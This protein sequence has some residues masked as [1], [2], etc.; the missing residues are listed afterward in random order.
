[1]E[2]KDILIS[3]S[4][5]KDVKITGKKIYIKHKSKRDNDLGNRSWGMIDKLVKT[6]DYQVLLLNKEQTSL[7]F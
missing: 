6:E 2:N 1:M 3:L 5:K 7:A 4:K